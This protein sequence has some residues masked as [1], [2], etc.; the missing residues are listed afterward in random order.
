M[1]RRGRQGVQ[2]TEKDMGLSCVQREPTE[3]FEAERYTWFYRNY[4]NLRH[5]VQI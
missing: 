2:I 1:A 3:G 5:V 4:I